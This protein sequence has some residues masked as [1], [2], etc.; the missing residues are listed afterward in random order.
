MLK[1]LKIIAITFLGI[2]AGLAVALSNIP[3]DAQVYFPERGDHK[4]HGMSSTVIRIVVLCA[5]ALIVVMIT[6]VCSAFSA[7]S[8]YIDFWSYLA[9]GCA[10]GLVLGELMLPD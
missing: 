8:H 1:I 4:E 2:I 5:L 7:H 6:A 9:I 10:V 3:K